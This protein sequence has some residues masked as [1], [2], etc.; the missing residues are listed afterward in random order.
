MHF[1]LTE[2][3]ASFINKETKDYTRNLYNNLPMPKL[4]DTKFTIN[5][6]CEKVTFVYELKENG[7]VP[8]AYFKK[9]TSTSIKL[10]TSKLIRKIYKRVDEQIEEGSLPYAFSILIKLNASDL[11]E[12]YYQVMSDN[13]LSKIENGAIE[14]TFIKPIVS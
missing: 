6:S 4:K 12:E 10:V 9:I 11:I 7:S 1:T 2:K 13:S 3:L 14:I 5:D 8:P